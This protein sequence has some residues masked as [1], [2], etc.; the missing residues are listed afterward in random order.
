MDK[1]FRQSQ[2][3]KVL[4]LVH[5]EEMF[6]E[7]FPEMYIPRLV[8]ALRSK[9]YD[10]VI[11][12]VSEVQSPD[13][14]RELQVLPHSRIVWGW[15]YEP[16]MFQEDE[17]PWVI[18]DGNLIHEHT[19]VPVKLRDGRLN[20]AQVFLGG[21]CDGECLADMEAVLDRLGVKFRRMPGYI[22]PHTTF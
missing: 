17:I 1:K 8:K 22:Y 9:K 5:V 11:C 20:N 2:K 21:G 16:S 14:I 12:M 4:I 7:F 19:W 18:S 3:R 10:E 15:S 13:L 6:R